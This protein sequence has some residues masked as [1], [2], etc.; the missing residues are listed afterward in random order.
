[1]IACSKCILKN[2]L[3]ISRF[4]KFESIPT[5]RVELWSSIYII[6]YYHPLCVNVLSPRDLVSR[7]DNMDETVPHT[8]KAV[9]KSA[10]DDNIVIGTSTRQP[11]HTI[12]IECGYDKRAFYLFS[13]IRNVKNV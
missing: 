1:M 3:N 8:H 9:L 13:C 4:L 11:Q 7:P 10:P 12:I 5:V 2:F 6:L